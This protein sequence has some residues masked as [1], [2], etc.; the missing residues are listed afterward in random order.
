[1]AVA[2]Y[3]HFVFV[4]GTGGARVGVGGVEIYDTGSTDLTVA[5]GTAGYSGE[6][7]EFSSTYTG[8]KAFDHDTTT[9]WRTASGDTGWLRYDLGAAADV[10]SL[11]FRNWNGAGEPPQ[12]VKVYGSSTAPSTT[13]TPYGMDLLVDK[14]PLTTTA[15]TTV[16]TTVAVGASPVA[17]ATLAGMSAAAKGKDCTAKLAAATF[18]LLHRASAGKAVDLIPQFGG[19]G[20]IAGTVYVAGSPNTP[21]PGKRVGLY[22]ETGAFIRSMLSDASGNYLFTGLDR[23]L[24]YFVVG[25]DDSH[26]Y[27]A[28]IK[29]NLTPVRA[30]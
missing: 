13:N 14:T 10:R 26:N 7:T 19:D 12:F 3:L 11:I 6:S 29:D 25:F 15:D 24:A 21:D 17:V 22:K 18:G 5:R 20:Y 28:A 16:S 2:R 23:S 8:S 1:M 27:G 9:A 4:F 30:S